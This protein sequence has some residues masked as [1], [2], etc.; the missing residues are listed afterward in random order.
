MLKKERLMSIMEMIDRDE[1]ITVSDLVESLGVSDMTV[2]RDLDE[3]AEAGKLVRIHG[4]AQKIA[5]SGK[6]E[7]SRN[8]KCELHGK[9]KQS[10]ARKAASLIEPGETIYVGPGTTNEL[11]AEYVDNVSSLR[12]VTNSLP[13]FERWNGKDGV[14][15]IMIGGTYRAKSGAFVGGLTNS[16][17]KD[18]KFARAFVGVNGIHDDRMMTANAEEGMTQLAA[19]NNAGLKFAV[20]DYH[21]LNRDDFYCFYSLY[22][23]DAMITN[24]QLGR[25]SLRHYQEYTK[26][27]IAE[28]S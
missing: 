20:C 18:L 2:R 27:I 17:I 21:K 22:N 10:V 4:G 13:V 19:L 25:D 14:E 1:I 28:D 24:G 5:V 6:E 11:I 12:V 9:E 23:M 8:E 16:A 3:L 7:L 15:V 26:M